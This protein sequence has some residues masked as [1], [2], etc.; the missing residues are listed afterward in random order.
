MTDCMCVGKKERKWHLFLISCHGLV[1][2]FAALQCF[3]F[4]QLEIAIC[5]RMNC[6]NRAS[7]AVSSAFPPSPSSKDQCW[8][9]QEKRLVLASQKQ[10]K[11]KELEKVFIPV[12]L[13]VSDIYLNPSHPHPPCPVNNSWFLKMHQGLSSKLG[14]HFSCERFLKIELKWGVVFRTAGIRNKNCIL[15]VA[16]KK[17]NK[18]IQIFVY[19]ID[20]I[21]EL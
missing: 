14:F 9:T 8:M 10:N 2:A 18:S 13:L 15:N 1:C 21:Y 6:V 16:K 7:S 4:C 12:M 17:K 3:L 19:Q 11:K 5:A 20:C